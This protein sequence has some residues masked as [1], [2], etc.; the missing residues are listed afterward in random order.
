MEIQRKT[1]T[2]IYQKDTII[3]LQAQNQRLEKLN[4]TLTKKAYDTNPLSIPNINPNLQHVNLL[5]YVNFK[6]FT[7]VWIDYVPKNDHYVGLIYDNNAVGIVQKK[8]NKAIAYLNGN[9]KCNYTV[10]IG[11]AKAPA[12]IHS[13][14]NSNLLKAR[15]IP[16]WSKI[17]VGDQVSTSGKDKIFFEGLSVGT[18]LQ[19]NKKPDSLEAIIQPNINVLNKKSFYLYLQKNIN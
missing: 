3:K 8:D 13:M 18:V 7:Q 1:D 15:Y 12:I 17:N 6:D 4:I 9:D 16:L 14:S 2:Y 11:E 10:F 5:S 19:I